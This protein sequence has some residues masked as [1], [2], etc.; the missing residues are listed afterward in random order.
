ML[1]NNTWNLW[2]EKFLWN[3]FYSYNSEWWNYGLDGGIYK[4]PSLKTLMDDGML[5]LTYLGSVG[6]MMLASCLDIHL[7]CL[8]IKIIVLSVILLGILKIL[9]WLITIYSQGRNRHIFLR[10]QS[11]FPDFLPVVK[12]FFPVENSHFGRPKTNFHHFQ[13]WK[14]KKNKNK[15][16]SSPHF[17]TFSCFHF[18][19]STFSSQFSPL[20]PFSLPFFPPI[21]RQKFPGQKSLGSTLPPACYAT[22]YSHYVFL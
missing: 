20:L 12:C 22:G 13:K 3:K 10:G 4:H 1:W 11:H 9:F 2:N 7:K 21:R 8:A 14:T 15:K 5:F 6:F 19:F 16:K 18:K 17:I